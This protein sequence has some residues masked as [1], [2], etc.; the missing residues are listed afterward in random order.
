VADPVPA[1]Y[2]PSFVA[3]EP[4]SLSIQPS[5]SAFDEPLDPSES[6]NCEYVDEPRLT[7]V[8]AGD[9]TAPPIAVTMSASRKTALQIS[10]RRRVMNSLPC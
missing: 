8:G 9:E 2:L 10:A 1:L 4:V 3:L 5:G 6:K 7:A